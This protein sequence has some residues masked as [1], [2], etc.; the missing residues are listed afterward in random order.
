MK[1]SQEE[2]LSRSRLSRRSPPAENCLCKEVK[3]RETGQRRW[4][5]ILWS[6]GKSFSQQLLSTVIMEMNDVNKAR[7][8]SQVPTSSVL[9][10]MKEVAVSGKSGGGVM[11]RSGRYY[12]YYRLYIC[13]GC[14]TLWHQVERRGVGGTMSNWKLEAYW[15]GGNWKVAE[16][17]CLLFVCFLAG[18]VDPLL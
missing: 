3:T 17:G 10:V 15:T 16:V 18:V 4:K 9:N 14:T 8:G 5:R 6:C 11:I 12:R 7:K 13:K 2:T 1:N